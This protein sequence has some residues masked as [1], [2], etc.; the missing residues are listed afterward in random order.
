M[1]SKYC[2]WCDQHL[3]QHDQQGMNLGSGPGDDT[4]AEPPPSPYTSATAPCMTRAAAATNSSSLLSSSPIPSPKHQATH[5]PPLSSRLSPST[6][7]SR[8]AEGSEGE[9]ASWW[10][11]L[12][13]AS[14]SLQ[15]TSFLSSSG[16]AGK[17]EWEDEGV[18]EEDDS[19]KD[20]K[21]VR[22]GK[23]KAYPNGNV[24][25]R[26]PSPGQ[27]PAQTHSTPH[28]HQRFLPHLFRDGR[29]FKV[30]FTMMELSE[31][32]AQAK[33][34]V[35]SKGQRQGKRGALHLREQHRHMTWQ[36]VV[37]H[38]S[39]P[40]E[41]A[42]RDLFLGCLSLHPS[43]AFFF[44][45]TPLAGKH[46]A[47]PDSVFEMALLPAPAL[48]KVRPN[49][50]TFSQH[51]GLSSGRPSGHLY[52][53][54]AVSFYNLGG[55]A[56]LVA[57]TPYSSRHHPQGASKAGQYRRSV[58]H[59]DL[60]DYAHLAAFTRSAPPGQQHEFWMQAG[61]S[62]QKEWQKRLHGSRASGSS[63]SSGWGGSPAAPAPLWVSTSGLGVS[64]LH[65]RLDEAPKYFQHGEYR[66]H[67]HRAEPFWAPWDA[68]VQGS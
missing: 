51:Y 35:R 41:P 68:A 5:S 47:L 39:N 15:S 12:L 46:G 40:D 11:F 27:P 67:R 16:A 20:K 65:L 50:N 38:W 7:S 52:E 2:Y 26:P 59:R 66:S 36:D 6:A 32:E 64:W 18:D 33:R 3:D 14:S 42:F 8:S 62:I 56:V 13:P 55:D 19:G 44:E 10:P 1:L 60:H 25:K 54:L 4:A 63:G 61:R 34:R 49:A 53:H 58:I 37:Q 48:A 30:Q 28:K 45:T 31:K 29:V 24:D 57:P 9:A 23:H 21:H 22:T 17:D 43:E